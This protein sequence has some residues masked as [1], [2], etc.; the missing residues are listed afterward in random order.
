MMAYEGFM[1]VQMCQ[2]VDE[3]MV[4]KQFPKLCKGYFNVELN[5]SDYRDWA[6]RVMR[7]YVAPEYCLGSKGDMVGV[8]IRDWTN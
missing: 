3:K 7:E 1:Y 6:I 4:Y 2:R 8:K 5:L